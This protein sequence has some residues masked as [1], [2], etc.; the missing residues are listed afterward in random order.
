MASKAQDGKNSSKLEAMIENASLSPIVID[1][2]LNAGADPK[3]RDKDGKTPWDYAK[4]NKSIK[5]SEAYWR[6]HDAR[7]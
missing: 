5:G 6:L 3:A 2:L 1:A 7:F 4:D